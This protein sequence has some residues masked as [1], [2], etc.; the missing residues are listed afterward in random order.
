MEKKEL[1]DLLGVEV[2]ILRRNKKEGMLIKRTEVRW[3]F[4]IKSVL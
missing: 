1:K 2:V 4:S 3:T